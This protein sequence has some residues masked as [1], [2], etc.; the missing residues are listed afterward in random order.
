MFLVLSNQCA[1]FIQKGLNLN[2]VLNKAN[3]FKNALN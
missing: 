2:F 1:K 3:K